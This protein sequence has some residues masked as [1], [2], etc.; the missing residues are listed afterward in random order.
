MHIVCISDTHNLHDQISMPEGNVLIH[1][2]DLTMNG[3]PDDI[4]AAFAWLSKQPHERIIAIPGNHDFG[5]QRMPHLAEALRSEFPRVELLIDQ[6]TTVEGV[7]VYG[8]PWQPWFHDWAYNFQ[9]GRDGEEQAEETWSKIPNDTGIL[10]THGPVREILDRTLGAAQKR[11]RGLNS[12]V[13]H[14]EHVGCPAL[15]QRISQL[16]NLR[17]HVCG[18]IHESYGADKHNKTLFVNACSCD[19][20]YSPTQPPIVV[21][22]NNGDPIIERPLAMLLSISQ[23]RDNLEDAEKRSKRATKR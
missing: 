7:R 10:V 1:A 16:H 9:T 3:D 22:W 12:L 5:F 18:H 17:L 21:D 2:G 14:G 19:A 15:R 4:A 8:S 23:L 6:E 11:T 13:A 20:Q